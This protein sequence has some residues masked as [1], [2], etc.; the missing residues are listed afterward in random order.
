M[1]I[2]VLKT[3][4]PMLSVNNSCKKSVFTPHWN[5]CHCNILGLLWLDKYK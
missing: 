1:K 3:C 5:K 4:G 2:Y